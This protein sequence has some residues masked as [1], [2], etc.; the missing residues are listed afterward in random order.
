MKTFLIVVLL[1][2]VVW[3]NRDR[4]PVQYQFWSPE[5]IVTVQNNSDQEIKDV[6]LVLWSKPRFLGVIPKGRKEELKLRR[7]R[8]TTD[9]L[10]RFH[11]GTETIERYVGTLNESSGYRMLIAVNYAGV[12]TSQTGTAA[13]E[14]LRNLQQ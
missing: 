8:E 2:V 12:I 9:V 4:I 5:T 7:E 13:Q 11:Y 1:G 3:S 6:A 10:I 14:M